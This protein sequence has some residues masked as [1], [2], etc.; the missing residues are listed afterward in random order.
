[1]RPATLKHG[2]LLLTTMIVMTACDSKDER[3]VEYAQ[4]ASQQ[5]ARQ[6]EA[7][8][9]QSEQVAR[10]S[11]ELASAAHDL[12][13][14]DAAARRD[15]IQAHERAQF[16]LHQQ[17]AEIDERRQELHTELKAAAEAAVREPVIAEA[18]IVAALILATLLPL[19]VTAYALRRLPDPGP[20]ETLLAQALLDDLAALPT[21]APRSGPPEELQQGAPAPRLPGPGGAAAEPL[22][23][24]GN[25]NA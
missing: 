18:L 19:I 6:N 20:G 10:Q 5:Q 11:Q 9:R 12:V 21:G 22:V 24:S 23:A 4:Q 7:M 2:V 13:E 17:Q 3:L 16:D 15:L 14:Q 25:P 8:A 1:M